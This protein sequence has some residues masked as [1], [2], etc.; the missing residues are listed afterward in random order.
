MRA[1][2]Q[3]LSSLLLLQLASLAITGVDAKIKRVKA[4]KVYKDHEEVHIVVNKVG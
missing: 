2:Q 3:V 1:F 4:G